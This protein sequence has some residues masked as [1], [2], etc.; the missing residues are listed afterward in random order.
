MTIKILT[1]FPAMFS[2]LNESIT[3]RAI[4]SGALKLE[5]IDIRPFSADKKH[6]KCD[7]APFGGGC[8]MIMTAQP[9]YDAVNAADPLRTC[10]RIFLSPRGETFSARKAKSLAA[11]Y[12][13][14]L[15][16]CGRYEGVD[17]R[18]ID[19]CFD[20]EISIGDYVLTGGE[21]AA[22][23]V[24]DAVSRFVPGVLGNGE[25]ASDESFSAGLLEYP[26]YTRP[27]E[28]M[29]LKV[30]EILLSGHHKNVEKWRAEQSGQITRRRRPDLLGNE[31]TKE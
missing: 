12:P 19:L 3:G 11:A 13:E 8:G 15:L 16:L 5:V 9:I 7:D 2:A 31:K 18:V 28:F 24:A 30:P 4:E 6:Y 22:M 27:A 25:S 26:Q 21:L 14:L 17:Q 10:R 20:E 29:G 1:L 23:V